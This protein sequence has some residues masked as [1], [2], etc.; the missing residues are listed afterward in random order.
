MNAHCGVRV[1]LARVGP[2]GPV[3]PCSPWRPAYPIHF[4]PTSGSWL[5][6]AEIWF[7]IVERHREPTV[8]TTTVAVHK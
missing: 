1:R 7:G 8:K 4:T 5:N 3:M 2:A 6:L